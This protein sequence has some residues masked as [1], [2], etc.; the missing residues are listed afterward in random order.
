MISTLIIDEADRMLD[1]GFSEQ[2]K[3]IVQSD[4]PDK[5]KRQNLMFCATFSDEIKEIA[6]NFLK[7]F[8]FVQPK[9]QAPKQIIQEIVNAPEN[10]KPK[11]LCDIL[12]TIKGSVIIFIDMKRKVDELAYNLNNEGFKVVSIHGNRNQFQRQHAIQ[13][14]SNGNVPILIA[15]DVASRGLDFPN[16]SC[17]INYEMPTNIEDY[18]HR[19][20]RTGRIG[21]VGKA[22]SFINNSNSM[23]FKKLYHLLKSQKQN[24]PNWFEE[25]YKSVLD[26]G[27][28]NTMN[29]I[30]NKYGNNKSYRSNYN[31]YSHYNGNNLHSTWNYNNSDDLRKGGNDTIRNS[32]NSRTNHDSYKISYSISDVQGNNDSYS[33][34]RHENNRNY[35]EEFVNINEEITRRNRNRSRSRERNDYGGWN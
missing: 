18:I 31:S 28:K 34:H 13:S 19:I 21:Q 11:I 20:G 3:Q 12:K 23:I 30:V 9:Q 17:V 8:Y 33:K 7:D 16:V 5:N 1:M 14:F 35:H 6:R 26:V 22:I 2:L 25:M 27:N 29:W 32:H 10:Q 4:I 24:I 15:T